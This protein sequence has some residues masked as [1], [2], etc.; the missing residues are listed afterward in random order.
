M[1]LLT[2][3]SRWPVELRSGACPGCARTKSHRSFVYCCRLAATLPSQR[4]CHRS[5][6][7]ASLVTAKEHPQRGIAPAPL[8]G[9]HRET[10]GGLYTALLLK[11]LI[12]SS[13]HPN[14]LPVSAHS[15]SR[16]PPQN[17]L[18][19]ANRSREVFPYCIS[20]GTAARLQRWHRDGCRYG[21]CAGRI[22]SGVRKRRGRIYGLQVIGEAVVERILSTKVKSL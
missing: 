7:T 11:A 21:D 9:C 15:L 2:T 6:P 22:V 16:S 19:P 20:V 14:P 10:I 3:Q 18:W 5:L 4:H 8:R 13:P 17:S 12:T 1:V